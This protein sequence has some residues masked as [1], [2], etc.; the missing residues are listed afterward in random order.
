MDVVGLEREGLERIREEVRME[1]RLRHF[2][3]T[4]KLPSRNPT[5]D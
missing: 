4:K 1:R 2:I 3:D 5:S